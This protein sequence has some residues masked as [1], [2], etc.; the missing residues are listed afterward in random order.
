MSTVI[1]HSS[2]TDGKISESARSI[3][4][5]ILSDVACRDALLMGNDRSDE[6]QEDKV[7]P[8]CVITTQVVSDDPV[9]YG[10][11]LGAHVKCKFFVEIIRN[12]APVIINND[13]EISG[14]QPDDHIPIKNLMAVPLV[15]HD[16]CHGILVL[17]NRDQGD[18]DRQHLQL[19]DKWI[20]SLSNLI[21]HDLVA[22]SRSENDSIPRNEKENFLTTMSHEIL[23]PL[24]AILGMIRL[25]EST[26]LNDDQCEYLETTRQSSTHLL[27]LINNIL[28]YSN[29]EANRM[30]LDEEPISIRTCVEEAQQLSLSYLNNKPIQVTHVIDSDVPKLLV[31]DYQH[32]K[33]ILCNLIENSVKYTEFGQVCTTVTW[34]RSSGMLHIVIKDTGIGIPKNYQQVVFE[35]FRKLETRLSHPNQGSGLGLAIVKQLVRLM[36][37]SIEVVSRSSEDGYGEGQTGTEMHVRLPLLPHVDSAS[38]DHLREEIER[39]LRNAKALVVVE[40]ITARLGLT[41]LL[42][43]Y[44]M[45]VQSCGTC[46]EAI[47]FLQNIADLKLLFVS[48]KFANNKK[49][50]RT[51]RDCNYDTDRTAIIQIFPADHKFK[52]TRPPHSIMK[53]VTEKQLRQILRDICRVFK[54]STESTA[55]TSVSHVPR[56]LRVLVVDDDAA[57]QKVVIG[58]LKNIDPGINIYC[59]RDGREAVTCVM[60]RSGAIDLILMDIRMPVMNGF[61]TTKRIRTI[62][63]S[64]DTRSMPYIVAMTKT[65][66]ENDEHQCLEAGMDGYIKKPIDYNELKAV[67]C[68]VNE[69]LQT[70]IEGGAKAKVS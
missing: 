19:V 65:N 54:Q 52:T 30:L 29:L 9:N 57:F 62:L 68:V 59:A 4:L 17:A 44:K 6:N 58:F 55:D 27:N 50:A 66:D 40:N 69:K 46:E 28:D 10:N 25:M 1:H 48:S 16:C 43:K 42:I 67:I 37:G 14:H 7:F 36:K 39:H 24:N 32:I 8:Y 11:I 49:L 12:K 53:P 70:V 31:G 61:E 45:F 47:L 2:T 21:Y 23:T 41:E 51:L 18:F 38:V 26:P 20:T 34:E 56:K 35:T 63:K 3:V 60:C 13:N 64:S 22:T 5:C 15:K 33:Q